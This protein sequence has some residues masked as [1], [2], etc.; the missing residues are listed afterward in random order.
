MNQR[1]VGT[2]EFPP[3]QDSSVLT[4]RG[5]EM[6]CY[7]AL[8]RRANFNRPYRDEETVKRFI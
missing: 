3:E 4:G 8:K 7:P 6:L 2:L 1:P 5:R